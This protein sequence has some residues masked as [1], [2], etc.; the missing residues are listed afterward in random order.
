MLRGLPAL[1][2]LTTNWD[3]LDKSKAALSL[4][5]LTHL[6]MGWARDISA[7]DMDALDQHCPRW[8]TVKLAKAKYI[9]MGPGLRMKKEVSEAEGE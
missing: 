6:T 9:R 4:P 2:V 3:V 7:G 1:E 5:S 8:R